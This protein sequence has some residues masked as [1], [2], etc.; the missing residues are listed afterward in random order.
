VFNGVP[1]KIVGVLLL[2]EKE[3]QLWGM[4]GSRGLSMLRGHSCT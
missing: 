1:P 2:A 3:A 4:A